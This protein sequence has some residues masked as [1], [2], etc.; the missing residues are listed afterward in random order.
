MTNPVRLASV[1]S[2]FGEATQAD[3]GKLIRTSHSAILHE[4]LIMYLV[5][6]THTFTLELLTKDVNEEF[7]KDHAAA[8]KALAPAEQKA[9]TSRQAKRSADVVKA[10]FAPAP[11]KP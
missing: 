2:K 8:F 4:P 9:I 3:I 1:L 6:D 5:V 11:V 10:H 7:N